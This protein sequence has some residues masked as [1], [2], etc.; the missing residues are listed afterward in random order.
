MDQAK[1][2]LIK[3]ACG[4]KSAIGDKD[5]QE[6]ILTHLQSLGKYVAAQAV[7]DYLAIPD[8]Q[9]CFNLS[10]TVSLS[11]ACRWMEHSGGYSW[12]TARNGQYVDG[13]EREDV[14][15]YQQSKFLPAWYALDSKTRKWS[16]N[17]INQLKD[18]QIL[19]DRPT[20]V[21]FHDESTFYTHDQHKK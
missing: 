21:W 7:V 8:V 14:V 9:Q 19:P 15:E 5:L 18:G 20:I 11:T 10:N 17:D 2:P 12:S 6:E 4:A 13:H 16:A 1:L 3:H